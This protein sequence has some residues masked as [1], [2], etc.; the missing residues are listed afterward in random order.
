MRPI[1]V[2]P[3][4]LLY[5]FL[6]PLPR[7]RDKLNVVLKQKQ[8]VAPVMTRRQIMTNGSMMGPSDAAVAL[9]YTRSITRRGPDDF[10]VE[11]NPLLF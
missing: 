7:P 6:N 1:I 5:H 11:G 2:V 8:M 3:V 4:E 10:L 9:R